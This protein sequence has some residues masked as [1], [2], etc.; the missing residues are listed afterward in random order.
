MRLKKIFN[1]GQIINDALYSQLI[2]LDKICFPGCANEFK[3][4][5]DWWVIE[6]KG[7]IVAYC[8]S[9]YF[10][11][12]CMFNRAWVNRNYRGQGWQRRMIKKRIEQAR[13]NK[14]KKV[15]TYTLINNQVSSNNL[16]KMGF[17][18]YEPE[19]KYVGSEVN[20]FIKSV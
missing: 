20:Y 13:Q 11:K 7:T 17:L 2:E 1:S 8:G 16:I 6:D 10:D 9:L 19:W 3:D 18:L 15:I 5:R 12:F 14:C 4:N